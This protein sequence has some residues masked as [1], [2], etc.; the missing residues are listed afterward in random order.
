MNKKFIFWLLVSLTVLLLVSCSQDPS[1]CPHESVDKTKNEATCIGAEGWSITCNDCGSRWFEETAPKLEHNPNDWEISVAPT[2]MSVGEEVRICPDCNETVERRELDAKGHT[3]EWVIAQKADCMNTGKR[4]KMCTACRA[5]LATEEMPIEHIPVTVEAVSPTCS[6]VGYVEYVKCSECLEPLTE[7]T[8]IEKLPHTPV[9]RERVEPTCSGVGYT[10]GEQ[11]SAC[12]A[13]TSG[14]QQIEKLAHTPKDSSRVEPTCTETGIEAG[15]ICTVCNSTVT[16]RE[17]I[18]ALGHHFLSVLTNVC[19]RCPEKEYYEIDSY[20]LFNKG[21]TDKSGAVIYLNKFILDSDTTPHKIILGKDQ[22]YLRL[23]GDAN[24]TYKLRIIIED[25]DTRIDIDFVNVNISNINNIVF[26]ES[27]AFVDLGFYGE[28]CSLIC[29]KGDTGKRG[30]GGADGASAVNV[31]GDLTISLHTFDCTITG[32]D[33][34]N[35]GDGK[36]GWAWNG[37]DGGSGGNG[38]SAVI[39]KSVSVYLY[40]GTLSNNIEFIKGKG[41]NGGKGGIAY[42][43]IGTEG[44]LIY[45]DGKPGENGYDA[46]LAVSP[47]VKF[48]I[49]SGK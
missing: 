34:G 40:D 2:C 46:E 14:H 30:E 26:S 13:W 20:E 48:Q 47:S 17:T 8:P 3:E 31:A 18:K 37:G 19:S 7:R 15:S 5:V 35:G 22:T 27:D 49:N 32:G 6:S 43:S 29:E 1:K 38:A 44:S 25:R 21:Y 10:E 36:D 42:S 23:V 41:G 16:G 4:H 39:A 9:Q 24:K 12:N 28:K 45:D 33:G 11:C